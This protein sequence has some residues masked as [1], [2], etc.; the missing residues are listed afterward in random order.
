LTKAPA[1]DLDATSASDIRAS[2]PGGSECTATL[3]DA[4]RLASVSRATASRVV[5]GGTRVSAT[6]CAAVPRAVRLLDH[7]S[8]PYTRALTDRSRR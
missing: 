3:E 7:T 4:A 8:D 2:G 1:R 5:N 6:T